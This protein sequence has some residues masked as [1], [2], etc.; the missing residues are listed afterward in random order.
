MAAASHDH[1]PIIM[2]L[3]CWPK[4]LAIEIRVCPQKNVNTCSR[5][6]NCVLFWKE[7][8]GALR[9]NQVLFAPQ[10]RW[11][12]KPW[13]G[14]F[15]I[16]EIFCCLCY[17]LK[18]NVPVVF[19]RWIGDHLSCTFLCTSTHTLLLQIKICTLIIT[20]IW[21]LLIATQCL[22]SSWKRAIKFPSPKWMFLM[23]MVIIVA[24]ISL[25]L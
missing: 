10:S 11:Q 9:S 21:N 13:K 22:P 25:L 4:V 5:V 2:F 3:L 7:I 12:R 18:Q 16:R 15:D 23:Y 14:I 19:Q 8:Y 24:L 20:K 17:H 1:S 6:A